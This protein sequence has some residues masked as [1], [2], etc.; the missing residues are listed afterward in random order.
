MNQSSHEA[1]VAALESRW[2]EHRV[3]P[4]LGRIDALMDMLGRPERAAP[5]IQITG[6]NGKG[7]TAIMIDALL[8]AN[9]LRVGR[10]CSPHLQDVTERISIDGAPISHELFDEIWE[11]IE[12]IVEMVDQRGID[13]VSCT[14]FEIMTAMA[15]VAFADAPVDVTVM[16]VGMGGR[17]DATSV[18]DAAVAVVAP[19]DLD[20]TQYL[21]DTV[22]KIASEKAGIIKPGAVA[23][24]AGQAPQ[25][26]QVLARRC[27]DVGASVKSEGEDFGLLERQLA[28]GG[29]VVRLLCGDGPVGDLF[30]PLHGAHM[31]HNAALAVA[32]C[33]ALIGR[34][35]DP[36]VIQQGF[37]AVSAP[38]RLELVHDDPPVV[39]DTAHN[40]HGVRAA[41][42]GIDEA[43]AFAPL[44]G[45]VAMM[46]DKAVQDVL[47]L[48]EPEVATLVVTQVSSTDRALPVGD[49]ASMA[50]DVFGP[51]RVLASPNAR[52]ALAEAQRLAKASGEQAGVLVIGSVYLAG[53][54]R[55]LLGS[56]QRREAAL[57]DDQ[58]F[59]EAD[60]S[61]DLPDEWAQW[62]ASH[63]DDEPW[64]DM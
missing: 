16:E 60:P 23:V 38:A 37:D 18:A 7:S 48:L 27:L 54:V 45:V 17:W 12:P 44:V 64:D 33:E 11:E 13:G 29:Q 43:F 56:Q 53:E 9:G 58:R 39:L 55:D 41:L 4:S 62:L 32:A 22:A 21:G 61:V 31:A 47:E 6:T 2:P 49:L 26:A 19:V 40:P 34:G 28:A 15:Y 35:L 30:L 42:A 24:I 1:I 5:M 20:H 59:V 3:A 10:F 51:D 50:G 46:R 8:E 63:D 52:A 25:A 36:Q 57:L 14:F